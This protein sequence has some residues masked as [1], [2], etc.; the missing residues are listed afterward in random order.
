MVPLKKAMVNTVLGTKNEQEVLERKLDKHIHESSEQGYSGFTKFGFY[1]PVLTRAEIKQ[2]LKK[3]KS[4]GYGAKLHLR[5]N[6]RN[7]VRISMDWS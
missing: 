4:E 1:C 6:R 2:V 5:S 7:E 3:Y